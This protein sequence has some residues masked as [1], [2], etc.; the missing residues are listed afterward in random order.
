MFVFTYKKFIFD[1]RFAE[2]LQRFNMDRM[3]F[4][5]SVFLFASPAA[6]IA[7]A[8]SQL[9]A[10]L[11]SRHIRFG[12]EFLDGQRAGDNLVSMFRCVQR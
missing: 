3:I 5:I 12:I 2:H 8:M 7:E 6:H 10:F 1:H 11:N 4:G 9:G